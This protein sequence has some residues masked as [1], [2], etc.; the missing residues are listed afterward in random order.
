MYLFFKKGALHL[1][2]FRFIQIGNKRGFLHGW[3]LFEVTN[4]HIFT[5]GYLVEKVENTNYYL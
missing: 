4:E 2:P 3:K 5:T 1:I